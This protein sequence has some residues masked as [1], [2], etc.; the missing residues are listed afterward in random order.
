MKS[1]SPI[2]A[3]ANFLLFFST[4]S[5]GQNIIRGPYLQKPTQNSI[6]IVW[7]TD[8]PCMS[9]VS[10][11]TNLSLS[12][13]TFSNLTLKT[14]H[15]ITIGGLI[16]GQKH[17]YR[18]GNGNTPLTVPSAK[19]SFETHPLPTNTEPVRIW[20]LADFGTGT[21]TQGRVR[22]SYIGNTGTE[23]TNLWLW[24]GDNAYFSG[25]DNEYQTK[26]FTGINGFSDLVTYMPF[27][28]IPGNHEYNG[29]NATGLPIN[30]TGP[31]YDIVDV[32]QQA[33][34]GGIASGMEAYYSFDYADIHFLMLNSE[35]GSSIRDTTSAFS[36]WLRQDL[37]SCTKKWKIAT[38]HRPPHSKGTHDSDTEGLM[39]DIR[40]KINPVLEQYG[41]DLVLSGHSHN[42][43][44]SCFMHGYYDYAA[45][46]DSTQ[47]VIQSGIGD[48]Q[49]PYIKYTDGTL[50]NKGCV[51]VV[52]G[53]GGQTSNGMAL[54]H[55]SMCRV[56][57]RNG[58]AGSLVLSI[59]GDTLATEYLRSTGVV[60][61]E[62]R[63]IK[64]STLTTTQILENTQQLSISPN[65]IQNVFRL[66]LD[67]NS[68]GKR[69]IIRDMNG[70]PV[71][72]GYIQQTE[73]ILDATA[74]GLSAGIYTASIMDEN[75]ILGIL[76]FVVVP[77]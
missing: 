22:D 30:H 18:I 45:Q 72:L 51:Y 48:T 17:Y 53:N 75:K 63:M 76:K 2:F 3:F 55:P 1:L 34:A 43:E 58:E 14:N 32:Y 5:F 49:N 40:Q 23:E 61:D 54:N 66:V 42:Y 20:A 4:F 11:G 16:A 27:Y 62:F 44:R 67:F 39:V 25:L 70:Y 21:T 60:Y 28:P 19:Y 38:I 59:N 41:V 36:T 52:C 29:I 33:E 69:L 57:G 31:Y 6:T 56:D 10:W 47:Y 37:Q 12:L 24:L 65:P 26:V 68:I 71:Y 74:I 8:F 13:G 15:S 50:A 35:I 73:L 64:K 77:F 46:W 9:T 7:R